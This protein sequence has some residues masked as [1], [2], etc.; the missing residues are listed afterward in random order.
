M[1]MP[2]TSDIYLQYVFYTLHG[3]G[4]V[5]CRADVIS[6]YEKRGYREVRRVPISDYVDMRGVTRDDLTFLEMEKI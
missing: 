3:A 4:V 5:S 1:Y 2:G 6:L